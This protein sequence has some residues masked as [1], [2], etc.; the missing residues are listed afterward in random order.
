M[1][2]IRLIG[3]VSLAI[4]T[5]LYVPGGAATTQRPPATERNANPEA[6]GEEFGVIIGPLT[7]EIKRELNYR[8]S[9]GV[10]VFEVIGD[11][12]AEEAGIKPK[13]IIT[14]INKTRV[15]D[16]EEFGRL[17]AQVL[18]SGNFTVATWEPGTA[19][20]QGSGQQMNFHFIRKHVD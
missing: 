17:L 15:H 19:E 20:E 13:S 3:A 16:M 1:I 14:E 2:H 5:L 12:P 8:L 18:P 9:D 6:L 7:E 11:S 4:L 10:A